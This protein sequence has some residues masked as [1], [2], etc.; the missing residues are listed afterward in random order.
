MTSLAEYCTIWPT[1]GGQQYYT[2]AVSTPAL[3]PI[4]S[5]LV[6]WAVLVGEISTGSSCALNSA[7]I[8]ESFVEVTHPDYDWKVTRITSSSTD[9]PVLIRSLLAV[10]DVVGLLSFLGWTHCCESSAEVPSPT[11]FTASLQLMTESDTF[12]LSTFLVPSGQL[13]EV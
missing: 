6:G 4:L 10:V 7:Q 8:I 9:E 5:Y 3:R 1:A 11:I 12:Q 13:L 2:Q